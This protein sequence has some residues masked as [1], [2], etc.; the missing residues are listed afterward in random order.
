M[1]QR[2]VTKMIGIDKNT[3][4]YKRGILTIYTAKTALSFM[5][6]VLYKRF[7]EISDKKFGTF[8]VVYKLIG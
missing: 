6:S 8:P 1:T 2:E 4:F 3:Y 7:E 5:Y